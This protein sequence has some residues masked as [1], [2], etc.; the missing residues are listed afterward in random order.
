[1]NYKVITKKEDSINNFSIQM[2]W[3]ILI[4]NLKQKY[5]IWKTGKHFVKGNILKIN[6]NIAT[7]LIFVWLSI[8]HILPDQTKERYVNHSFRRIKHWPNKIKA[9]NKNSPLM[10]VRKNTPTTY[11]V[12][13]VTIFNDTTSIFLAYNNYCFSLS[14]L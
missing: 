2:F 5:M 10:R 7:L 4:F 3:K 8:V 12:L 9:Q 14:L 6:K 13:S 11:C 1:M